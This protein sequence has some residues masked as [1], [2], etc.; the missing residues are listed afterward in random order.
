[1]LALE[2][3]ILTTTG[4]DIRKTTSATCNIDGELTVTIHTFNGI[5]ILLECLIIYIIRGVFFNRFPQW[6]RPRSVK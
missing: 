5:Y 4:I 2:Q 3:N 6:T 1:M